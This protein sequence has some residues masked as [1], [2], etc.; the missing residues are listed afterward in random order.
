MGMRRFS[1]R[2]ARLFNQ[3]FTSWYATTV[4][5]IVWTCDERSLLAGLPDA[6]TPWSDFST[7]VCMGVIDFT[8]WYLPLPSSLPLWRWAIKGTTK[9]IV[10]VAQICL[11]RKYLAC[12]FYRHV[13]ALPIYPSWKWEWRPSKCRQMIL[14]CCPFSSESREWCTLCKL[15]S[16]KVLTL[17][18]LNIHW[19][20][21][22]K[23]R[24]EGTE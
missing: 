6:R 19:T 16:Y 11:T 7:R 18:T 12:H 10:R 21:T 15:W 17:I 2:A 5:G 24:L 8:L 9:Y 20:H 13:S 14:L 22:L 1:S 4:S 3:Y 23:A